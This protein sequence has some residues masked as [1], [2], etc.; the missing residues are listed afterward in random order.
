[1][2]ITNIIF[3]LLEKTINMNNSNIIQRCWIYT[4][5][6]ISFYF[7]PH[8]YDAF[9]R[10]CTIQNAVVIEKFKSKEALAYCKECQKGYLS[11]FTQLNEQSD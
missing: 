5:D 8:F 6:F 9:K 7:C 4:K 2:V 1:M 10:M 3:Q 11:H